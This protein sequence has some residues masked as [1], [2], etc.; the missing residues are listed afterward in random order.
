MEQNLK[1]VL[2]A[3]HVQISN[4]VKIGTSVDSVFNVQK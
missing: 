4:I 3:A 2:N 1:F